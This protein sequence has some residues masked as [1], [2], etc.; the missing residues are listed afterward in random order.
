LENLSLVVTKP[1]V[2]SITVPGPIPREGEQTAAVHVRRFG[3]EPQPVRVQFDDGPG[4]ISAP[5]VVTIPSDSS[6]A[7]IRLTAAADAP[8][9]KFDNLVVE[10]STVV[11]GQRITVHSQPAHV[12]VQPAP[13]RDSPEESP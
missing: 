1:L 12:E 11:K 7:T 6:D 8:L 2:V 5:I 4:G 3:D 10:A 13:A 9:G